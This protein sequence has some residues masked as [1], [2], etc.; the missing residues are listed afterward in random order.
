MHGWGWIKYTILDRTEI[1][2]IFLYSAVYK[3][4]DLRY[5]KTATLELG[6]SLMVIKEKRTWHIEHQCYIDLDIDRALGSS[7]FI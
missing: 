3:T 1:G 2:H 4:I 7:G 6:Q 5:F